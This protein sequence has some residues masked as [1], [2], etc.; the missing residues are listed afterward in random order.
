L[1]AA[2]SDSEDDS[3]IFHDADDKWA[4]VNVYS[5][6]EDDGTLSLFWLPNVSLL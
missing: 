4:E 6:E 1:P 5:A 3:A 2:T